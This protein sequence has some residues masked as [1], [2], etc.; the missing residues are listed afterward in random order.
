MSKILKV[1]GVLVIIGILGYGFMI[2]F[3]SPDYDNDKIEL[4]NSFLSKINETD[5]CET[6]FNPETISICSSFKENISTETGLTFE[7]VSSTSGTIVTFKNSN[8]E[9]LQ[10]EFTFTEEANTGV[11][12]LF[13]KTNYRIDLI[14]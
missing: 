12:G 14:K 7:V 11:S 13:H 9:E 1:I 10:Y 3:V 4:T 5:V 8:N 2:F 6:H